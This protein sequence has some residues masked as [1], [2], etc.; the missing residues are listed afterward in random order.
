MTLKRS[1]TS[2]HPRRVALAK[3]L[4]RITRIPGKTSAAEGNWLVSS[5]QAGETR[6]QQEYLR[7]QSVAPPAR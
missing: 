5:G 2:P 7:Q 1:Q 6:R 3:A 4:A